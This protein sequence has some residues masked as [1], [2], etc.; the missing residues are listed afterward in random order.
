MA[1]ELPP[2]MLFDLDDT[3]LEYERHAAASWNVVANDAL[4]E[5]PNLD[6]DALY[7]RLMFHRKAFWKNQGNVVRGRLNLVWAR[8]M[9]IAASYSD[10]GLEPSSRISAMA[11]HYE[12]TREN[13]I[14]PFPKALETIKRIAAGNSLLGMVTNGAGPIQRA[15]IRRFDLERYFQIIVVEGEF[16]VGKPDPAP[17]QQALNVLGSMPDETWMIGNDLVN[18]IAPAMALGIS[19]V[20]VDWDQ[21]GLP[22]DTPVQPNRI[23]SKIADLISP[24]Y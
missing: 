17:F 8:R 19:T 4:A 10:L 21:R 15:K 23:V 5:D 12:Q 11:E 24:S 3:I 20:W 6:R 1:L 13:A 22:S 2:F 14:R 16:G 7:T 18:D 9:V